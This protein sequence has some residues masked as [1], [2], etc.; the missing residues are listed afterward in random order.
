MKILSL[1]IVTIALLF[2]SGMPGGVSLGAEPVSG[3]P[4]PWTWPLPPEKPRVQF[5]QTIITPQD[6]G[7]KKGFFAK[8]WEFIVGEDTANRIMSPHGV[9]ADGEGKLYVADWGGKQIHF[10]DFRKKE[11]DVFFKTRLGPLE[12]P[13]GL[14][15]DADG[16]LYVTD[17]VL[18]RIFVFNGTK[19]KKVLGDDSLLRPTGIAIN[20][21]D[22]LLYVADTQGHRIDVFDLD[23]K[24]QFSF[25][26]QGPREGEFNYPTHIAIDS[27][28]DVYVM[29]SLNFRVQIFD[30]QGRFEK[31]FGG[32]GTGID[33]FMK[34]KGIAVDSEGHIWVSDNLRNTIQVFDR[35]GRFLLIFGKLGTDAGQ[36]NIPAGLY[37]DSKDRLYVADSYNYRVQMYQY[38][39]QPDSAR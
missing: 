25:G 4:T 19:N 23:G 6:L 26:R 8:L 30:K 39:K 17:S 38:I 28:G 20:K 16:L 7:V 11:Y 27:A 37:I 15:L 32:N 14:A 31:Q 3:K 22:K 12:S 5:I 34:P 29:D 36:F 18:R 1:S 35:E 21:K 24:K 10:F 13:I 33:Q 2:V 9:V